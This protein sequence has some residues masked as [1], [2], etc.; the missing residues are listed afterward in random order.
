MAQLTARFSANRAVR[1]YTETHYLPAAERY[2]SRKANDCAEGR[3]LA[4]WQS[5]LQRSWP[6]LRFNDA[7]IETKDGQHVFECR[8]ALADIDPADVCAQL[9][10]EATGDQEAECHELRLVEAPTTNA[11]EVVF[12]TTI[13]AHRPA[14]SYT[15]RLIPNCDDAAVPLE[16]P[17]IL[18][19]R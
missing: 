6:R 14:A 4:R 5:R 1:E 7:S 8:V 2:Q 9:Y 18:W 19:Q 10:A 11:G 17:H 12:R 3:K 16:S 15:A 13:P